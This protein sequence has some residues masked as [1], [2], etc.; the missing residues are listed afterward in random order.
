MFKRLIQILFPRNGLPPP[1]RS[2]SRYAE[3]ADRQARYAARLERQQ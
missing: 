1:D 3:I 2:C